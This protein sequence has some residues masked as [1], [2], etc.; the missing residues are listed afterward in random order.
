MRKSETA[1]QPASQQDEKRRMGSPNSSK[2]G[3][4][5]GKTAEANQI[6]PF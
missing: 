3:R 6:G 5:K 1:V 2:E 4:K